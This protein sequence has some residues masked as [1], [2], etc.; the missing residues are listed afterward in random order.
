MSSGS[1]N[2]NGRWRLNLEVSRARD[3]EGRIGEGVAGSVSLDSLAV[4]GKLS[5]GGGELRMGSV[6]PPTGRL[7]T[8]LSSASL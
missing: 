3:D 4:E 6:E 8:M 1:N 5:G 2:E 7:C